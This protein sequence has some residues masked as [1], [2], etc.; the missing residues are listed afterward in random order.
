MAAYFF[1]SGID[2]TSGVTSSSVS[3]CVRYTVGSSWEYEYSYTKTVQVK[4]EKI[5][6]KSDWFGLMIYCRGFDGETRVKPAIKTLKTISNIDR[7]VNKRKA[8]LKSLT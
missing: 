5:K 4:P 7:K 8:Y 3:S 2:V 6:V 1:Y